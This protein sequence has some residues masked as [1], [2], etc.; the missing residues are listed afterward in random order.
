MEMGD[1]ACAQPPISISLVLEADADAEVDKYH[2]IYLYVKQHTVTGLKYFGFTKRDPYTYHGSGIRW[3][4]H[5]KKHG[6]SIQTLKVYEFEDADE[7][8]RFAIQFSR[9]NDIVN[10]ANWANLMEEDGANGGGKS[11]VRSDETRKRM[12]DARKGKSLG[13]DNSFFGK[14]HTIES[15]QKISNA[16]KGTMTGSSNHFFGKTHSEEARQKVS[17]ANK[18]HIKS[19]ATRGLSSAALGGR[20]K[21]DSFKQQIKDYASKRRWIVNRE[22]QTA[23]CLDDNDPRLLSGHWQ[24]GKKW[25]ED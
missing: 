5:C 19:E 11:Y 18:G 25:K 14:T 24:F 10:S 23:H 15:R 3:L 9:D 13:S 1:Q 6:F 17:I 22:G 7:C 16:K 20:P 21:P 2:M 4:N 12:S 8:R